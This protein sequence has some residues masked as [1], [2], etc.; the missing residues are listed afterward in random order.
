[1]HRTHGPIDAILRPPEKRP[2]F[3]WWR[4]LPSKLLRGLALLLYNTRSVSQE[5]TQTLPGS[6]AS[7]TP[8]VL[9]LRFLRETYNSRWRP[10]AIWYFLGSRGNLEWVLSLPHLHR[11]IIA[12]NHGVAVQSSKNKLGLQSITDLQTRTRIEFDK[13]PCP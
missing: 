2:Q 11:V 10:D 13:W 1:M 9:S 7:Q 4:L 6:C 3:P 12:G 5:S 8:K